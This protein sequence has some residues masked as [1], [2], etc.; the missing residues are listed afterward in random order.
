ARSLAPPS[1]PRG[2]AR[3]SR[4]RSSRGCPM[5]WSSSGRLV[6]ELPEVEM[7]ARTLRPRIVGRRVVDV[8]VSGKALRRPIDR[9]AL[10]RACAGAVVTEVVRTAKYLLVHLSSHYTLVA[11]LGMS[12]R[13]VFAGDG[14]AVAPH[15]HARFRLDAGEL[16]YVDARRFGVLAVYPAARVAQSPELSVLGL[17]P[18]D[19]A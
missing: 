13:L 5:P 10:H 16:R 9:R 18:L 19:P 3:R 12:G 1:I 8:E 15:T 14:E 4:W 7:V 2:A 17:D 6:P 11:H